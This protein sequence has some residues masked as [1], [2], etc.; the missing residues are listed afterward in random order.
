LRRTVVATL[1]AA[2]LVLLTVGSAAAD[3]QRLT[4][5]ARAATRARLAGTAAVAPAAWNQ[6]MGAGDISADPSS[7]SVADLRTAEILVQA[8]PP[9][10]FTAGDNQ[11]PTGTLAQYT[12]P[13]GYAGS[14]G[15]D[16]L[17]AKTCPAVGNH[18]YADPLPGPAGYLAYFKPPCPHRPDV[19]V[20]YRDELT[21]RMPTPEEVQTLDLGAGVPV[22]AYV[23]TCYTKERPVR[24]TETI[25]A[26]DRNRLVYE[27]GDLD[28]L[29]ERDR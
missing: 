16:V 23:R 6:I 21:T 11:Y 15:Q 17:K 8:N 26:G 7:T 12:N 14:W 10:V 3:R 5:A 29:Y 9:T 2:L 27:L 13:D 25:F 4:P 19:E 22:L 1:A 18:E 20:G 24:L 28:A